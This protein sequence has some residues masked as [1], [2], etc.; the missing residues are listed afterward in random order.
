MK[1]RIFAEQGYDIHGR[2]LSKDEF[3]VFCDREQGIF[4][5]DACKEK[6]IADAEVLVGKN[7]PHLYATDYMMYRRNGD[8]RLYQTPYFERRTDMVALALA[9]YVEG[10]GRFTDSL[11]NLVWMILEET[12]WVVPAHNL[13]RPDGK[14]TLSYA[15]G[16]RVDYIDLFSAMTGAELAWVWYLCRDAMGEVSE[17][18]SERILYELD[19]RIVKPYLDEA[20]DGNNWWLGKTKRSVNNNWC[21]W[22]VSNILNVVAFTVDDV[23]IR[24]AAIARAMDALD[25]FIATYHE[26]GGCDEGPSYW[27]A[28]GGGLYNACLVLGDMTNGYINIFKDPLFIRMGEYIA[29]VHVV[30]DRY[31]NFA[32]ASAKLSYRQ[33]YGY[34]WGLLSGSELMQNFWRSQLAGQGGAVYADKAAIPYRYVRQLAFEPLEA[35]AEYKPPMRVWFDG[36]C[37]AATREKQNG[38][39]LYLAIKGGHNA[40]SHNHND[41]GNFIIYADGTP[42]FLDAG[43]GEYTKR[44][45]SPERYT[46]WS[47]CSEYHNTATFCGVGQR[48]G[49]KY[50]ARD[51]I[52]DQAT[53]GL[54]MDLT[55]AY[56]TE[57]E[58]A[59]YR[60]EAVLANGVIK[61]TDKFTLNRDGDVMFS[62]ICDAVPAEVT[63]NS[64]TLHGRTVTFDD[65]LSYAIAPI[66]CNDLETCELPAAW[67]VDTLYR[68]TLTAPIPANR[69][70]TFGL[71]VR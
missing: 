12:S 28:A 37:V 24:E 46:I 62:L 16:E 54:S 60:R 1:R 20:C 56:P 10:K 58:L 39:G 67:D 4:I 52:Y 55:A 44:T 42:I 31:L 64:F 71:V 15:Y 8:R 19:R 69:E 57:S 41:V 13:V 11:I 53:G 21:P 47:M 50:E 63:G 36:L 25:C 3:R 68:I 33:L 35:P 14:G 48:P 7:Y 26:D 9:E 23:T 2:V 17:V 51:V 66:E 65:A 40:E 6:I 34:D 18:V 22:I 49:R 70:M 59:A 38:E 30:G 61:I 5:T 27:N 45:F 32:D 29:K 43:V